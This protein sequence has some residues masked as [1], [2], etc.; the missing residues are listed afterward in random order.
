MQVR[1]SIPVRLKTEVAENGY[2]I[3]EARE[4]VG[5]GEPKYGDGLHLMITDGLSASVSRMLSKPVEPLEIDSAI[6]RNFAS[7]DLT[8]ESFVGFASQFGLLGGG[9]EVPIEVPGAKG[10]AKSIISM[11]EPVQAWRNEVESL[12]KAINLW[13][14]VQKDD[15]D[16][17]R[18]FFQEEKPKLPPRYDALVSVG[19]V[20]QPALFVLKRMIRPRLQGQ[21]PLD[22]TAEEDALSP[23]V[24]LLPRSHRAGH[25]LMI[26]LDINDNRQYRS[27]GQCGKWFEFLTSTR[28]TTRMYCSNACRSKTYRGRQDQARR[29]HEEG[30]P[31]GDIAREL[32]TD[33]KTVKRWVGNSSARQ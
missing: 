26:S 16:A 23:A 12:R 24:E 13:E 25:W 10:E 29:L 33:V 22:L 5:G 6:H 18:Q 9:L 28:R 8:A 2:K 21:V 14:L 4:V 11:G 1:G 19:K 32:E 3:L 20:R 17:M 27:C 30:V 15:V 7:L 31:S